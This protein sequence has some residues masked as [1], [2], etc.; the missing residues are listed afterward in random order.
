MHS[1]ENNSHLYYYRPYYSMLLIYCYSV[2]LY[3]KLSVGL[4]VYIRRNLI[5]CILIFII[6]RFIHMRVVII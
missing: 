1:A 5:L 3:T 6:V 4:L 2:S